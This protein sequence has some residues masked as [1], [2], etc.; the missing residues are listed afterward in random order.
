MFFNRKTFFIILAAAIFTL[1]FYLVWCITKPME[2]HRVDKIV[3]ITPGTSSHAIGVLLEHEGLIRSPFVFYIYTRFSGARP[4][5]KAGQYK[6]SK[7]MNMIQIVEAIK[8]GGMSTDIILT[9]PEGFT[10]NQI[11][12]LIS[13]KGLSTEERFM[14][15]LSN[16]TTSQLFGHIRSNSEGYLFPDTY[17]VSF[18]TYPSRLI[19]LMNRRFEEVVLPL[20]SQYS[21]RTKLSLDQ[22]VILASII[23]KEAASDA[24]MPKISS[25]FHNR[26]RK[27]MPLQSEA[28]LRYTLPPGQE[29]TMDQIKTDSPYNTYTKLGLPEGPVCNPGKAAIA[30]ALNPDKSQYLFFMATGNGHHV[31]SYTYSQHNQVVAQYKRMTTQKNVSSETSSTF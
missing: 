29:I 24:E 10:V 17:H 12:K 18:S 21:S 3:V 22:I 27:R 9:I 7:Q 8:N 1:S 13:D 14:N 30:A 20:Y 15:S 2:D 6:L 23:Q 28:T 4:H 19:D 26:L 31:F 25:V 16:N 11:S 5:L